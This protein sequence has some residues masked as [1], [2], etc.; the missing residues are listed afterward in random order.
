MAI[1]IFGKHY[2]SMHIS[3][4]QTTCDSQYRSPHTGLHRLD[5]CRVTSIPSPALAVAV[6]SVSS[7]TI[8]FLISPFGPWLE[9]EAVLFVE[10]FASHSEVVRRSDFLAISSREASRLSDASGC[11]FTRF[12]F[13][14]TR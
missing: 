8:R 13:H 4:V 12:A 9:T 11:V 6:K 3:L 5:S 10:S 7:S 14:T 1:M 2:M